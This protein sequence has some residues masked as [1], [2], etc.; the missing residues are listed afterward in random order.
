[1]WQNIVVAI[2]GILVSIHVIKSIYHKF[3]KPN[4]SAKPCNGCSGCSLKKVSNE[5]PKGSLAAI[6]IFSRILTNQYSYS[7]ILTL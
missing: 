6:S 5:V 4:K 3:I 1:M 7:R 2:I